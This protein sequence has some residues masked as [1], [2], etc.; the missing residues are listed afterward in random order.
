LLRTKGYRLCSAKQGMADLHKRLVQLGLTEEQATQVIQMLIS[1]ML[2][3]LAE[4]AALGKNLQEAAD[5]MKRLTEPTWLGRLLSRIGNALRNFILAQVKALT[6]RPTWLYLRALV[7][8]ALSQLRARFPT[9]LAAIQQ[10]LSGLGS[11]V[12]AFLRA[13]SASV[14][15]PFF[16]ARGAFGQ[17][18]KKHS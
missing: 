12:V 13:L 3:F 18:I 17:F 7:S 6:S 1:G 10:A 2:Q 16:T 14:G 9:Q 15:A 4:Q 8:V 11:W 5:A